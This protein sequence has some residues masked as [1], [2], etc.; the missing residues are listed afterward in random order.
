MKENIFAHV[1]AW[2]SRVRV[3]DVLERVL[4]GVPISDTLKTLPAGL[5]LLKVGDLF[6]LS[7]IARSQIVPES[8]SLTTWT[9]LLI[10]LSLQ[11]MKCPSEVP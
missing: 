4:M 3:P 7:V 8:S 10:I 1:T 11:D 2:N 5:T 9:Y 6:I